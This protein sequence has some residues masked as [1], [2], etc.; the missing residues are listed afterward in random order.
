M[1]LLEKYPELVVNADRF[2]PPYMRACLQQHEL[3]LI[4]IYKRFFPENTG[5]RMLPLC[6]IK[7][8]FV[9]SDELEVPEENPLEYLRSLPFILDRVEH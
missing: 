4:V 2:T 1:A 7:Q 8:Y 6:E 3:D 5:C 9:V